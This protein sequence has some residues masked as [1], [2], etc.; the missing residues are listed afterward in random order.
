[1]FRKRTHVKYLENVQLRPSGVGEGIVL[2][3]IG[4]IVGMCGAKG[5]WF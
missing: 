2:P 4:D 3:Y 1:M 5:V